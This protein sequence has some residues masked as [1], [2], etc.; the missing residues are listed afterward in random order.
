M[1]QNR[2]I[3]KYSGLSVMAKASLWFMIC[4][5]LQKS[6]SLLT[7]PIFTRLLTTIQYGQFTVFN[8]WLNLFSIITTFRLD[9]AVFNKGMSK[10]PEERDQYTS[11]MQGA[12]N[13]ITLIVFLVYLLFRQEINKVTELSTFVT[14]FM[15]LELFFMPAI[16]FWTL[17]Q[18]YEYK[19]KAVVV[20][21]LLIAFFN[22]GLGVIAVLIAEEK[23]LARIFSCIIVETC[24]GF[25][26]YTFNLIK[27]RQLFNKKYI[28]FAVAFNMPLMVYYFSGYIL[29]QVDRIMIQKMSGYE[30]AAIYG[31]AYNVGLVLSF[32]IT[33]I[34]SAFTPWEYEMLKKETYS[35]IQKKFHP[36]TLAVMALF[37]LFMAFAPEAVLILAGEKYSEATYIIPAVTSSVVFQMLSALYANI[38]FYYDKN[39]YATIISIFE[40]VLNIILN[41]F[42]IMMFG[43][44]AAG[45]TTLFCY[46]LDTILH[47]IYVKK[48]FIKKYNATIYSDKKILFYCFFMIFITVLMSFLYKY[49]VL[50]YMTIVSICA[51]AI[52]QRKKLAEIANGLLRK[53]R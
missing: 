38:E 37:A 47:H 18:R 35:N 36:I 17:R 13:A 29:Q 24:F 25:I 33:S 27:G 16:R 44:I 49:P 6:I 11:S 51:V 15:F 41:Y 26:L 32:V 50:R 3:Q 14:C 7:T 31:I 2:L 8:S 22:A 19:Y 4:G 34:N 9:Y 30:A 23:G 28:C 39:K 48:I 1:T 53:E 21:T 42:G 46:M 12:T 40:A 45:Y 10:F 5:I 20:I 43:Y 52:A